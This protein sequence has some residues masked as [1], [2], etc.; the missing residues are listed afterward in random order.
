M[1]LESL[2]PIERI[3]CVQNI[4][5]DERTTIPPSGVNCKQTPSVSTL[6]VSGDIT[7]GCSSIIYPAIGETKTSRSFEERR[8][9]W[10]DVASVFLV[11]GSDEAALEDPEEH[12][13][14][15]EEDLE[16]EDPDEEEEEGESS[17]GG[18]GA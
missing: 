13:P 11:S 4:S 15:E 1:D 12:D 18:G 8:R 3:F 5:S 10:V 17:C 2:P 16:E 7:T 14:D 9:P 6:G